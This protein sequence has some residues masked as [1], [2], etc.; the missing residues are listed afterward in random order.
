MILYN[1]TV[2]I[3]KEVEEEWLQ[4]MKQIHIPNVLN[5]GMFTDHKI[6]RIMSDEPQGTSYSIQFFANTMEKLNRYQAEFAPALQAETM[7]KYGNH[8]VAFRTLLESVE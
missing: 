6:F 3:D 7:Q 4:W 2:N 1:V 8:L 5:T